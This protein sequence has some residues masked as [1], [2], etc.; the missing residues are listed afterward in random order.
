MKTLRTL[1]AFY[2]DMWGELNWFGRATIFLVLVVCLPLFLVVFAGAKWKE[3]YID[4]D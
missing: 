4:A 1:L 3:E 2:R